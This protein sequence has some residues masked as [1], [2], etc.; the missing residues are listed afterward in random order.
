MSQHLS[1]VS[2]LND[3]VD[4]LSQRNFF[5]IYFYGG[6]YLCPLEG[7]FVFVIFYDTFEA[8]QQSFFTYLF[9]G[10]DSEAWSC[11]IGYKFIKFYRPGLNFV[12][13]L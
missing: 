1:A 4:A 3:P 12:Y 9:A 13:V 2:W 7:S 10:V 8:K 5:S 11:F 6:N